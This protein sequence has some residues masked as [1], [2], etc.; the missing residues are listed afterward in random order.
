MVCYS[1]NNKG[2]K[3]SAEIGT[4]SVYALM[5]MSP[6]AYGKTLIR[7]FRTNFPPG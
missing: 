7:Y 4:L 5:G 3:E 6:K 1:L 2:L